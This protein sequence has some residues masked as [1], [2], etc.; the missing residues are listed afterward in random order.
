MR[1][2]QATFQEM[3]RN[4]IIYKHASNTTLYIYLYTD[5]SLIYQLRI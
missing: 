2:S 1:L 4:L 5:Y 3:N